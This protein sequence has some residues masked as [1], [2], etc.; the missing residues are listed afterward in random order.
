MT[1]E[2][3][4]KQLYDLWLD[5]LWEFAPM[6]KHL[7]VERYGDSRGVYEQGMADI[8]EGMKT[9]AQENDRFRT[10]DEVK[11]I[12]KEMESLGI[13]AL[14]WDDEAF[15]DCLRHIKNPPWMIYLLGRTE[16]LDERCV[17]VVGARK[18]TDYGK[19]AAQNLGRRIAATGTVVVSGMA[20]GVDSWAHRGALDIGLGSE[21]PEECFRQANTIAVLA[22]G[23]N[24][25]YPKANRN[26]Y[27]EICRRGLILSEFRPGVHPRSYYFPM[28]NRLISGL[29]EATVVVEAAVGSGS[30]I[31]AELAMDQGREVFAVPGNID[32]IGSMG[33]NKLIKDGA[34]ILI[35]VEDLI[36]ELYLEDENC[37]EIGDFICGGNGEEVLGEEERRVV[38]FLLQNGEANT[39]QLVRSTGLSASKLNGLVTVLEMK[40]IVSTAIGKIF[41]AKKFENLYNMPL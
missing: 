27:G 16:L 4:D 25:C 26:L 5:S 1:E 9:G 3:R 7:L 22:G 33:T 21:R 20:S 34:T 6:K 28:R 11:T 29:S 12:R 13:V 32:R 35:S 36:H 38:K 37:A 23:V 40:G 31:T 14:A 30:L 24:V 10:L 41:L 2:M 8:D 17:A 19:T 15:P 39:E 18:A